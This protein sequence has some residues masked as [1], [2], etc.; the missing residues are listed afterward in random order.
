MGQE[1]PRTISTVR[2][3]CS[4]MMIHSIS[5]QGTAIVLRLSAEKNKSKVSIMMRSRINCHS[6][7][8]IHNQPFLLHKVWLPGRIKAQLLSLESNHCLVQS[9]YQENMKVY[10]T[11]NSLL[12]LSE[13]PCAPILCG[14]H[15]QWV[16]LLIAVHFPLSVV[17]MVNF[18]NIIVIN[19]DIK[20]YLWT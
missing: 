9:Y 12:C 19:H 3:A 11:S 6:P 13:E 20:L 17:I 14:Y 2:Y 5:L 16:F 18:K 10:T 8:A 4:F 1:C 15:S 7:L